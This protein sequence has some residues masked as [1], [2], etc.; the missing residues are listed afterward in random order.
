MLKRGGEK[1]TT[2]VVL[3][4]VI[5]S[6]LPRVA[7]LFN[8]DATIIVVFTYSVDTETVFNDDEDEDVPLVCWRR[9]CAN[10]VGPMASKIA[11]TMFNESIAA[12]AG[13]KLPLPCAVTLVNPCRIDDR[14]YSYEKT[15]TV[16]AA[17]GRGVV[18]VAVGCDDGGAEGTVTGWEEGAADG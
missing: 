1:A 3:G 13:T 5:C 12:V 8:R 7:L 15:S 16:G 2:L 4:N 18:G 14:M 17:V 10:K 11:W 9:I 6:T